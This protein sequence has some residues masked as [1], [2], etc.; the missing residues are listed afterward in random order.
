MYGYAGKL[1]QIDLK[2]EKAKTDYLKRDEVKKYIGGI[3]YALKL[4]CDNIKPNVDPLGPE[5][6][7]V[8]T[9][10]PMSGIMAPTGWAHAFAAKSPLTGLIGVSVAQGFF[11]RNMKMAG[12]DAIIFKGKSRNPTF[13]WIDDGLVRFMDARNLWGKSPA[14]TEENIRKDLGDNSIRVASIGLSGERLARVACV[15]N[16]R[17]RVAGRT[18]M[19][20]VMGSKNLKAIAVLGSKDLEVAHLDKLMNFCKEFYVKA[21]G[22]SA[23]KYYGDLG[24]SEVLA[25]RDR[26]WATIYGGTEKYRDLGTSENLLVYNALGCLPTRNFSAGTFEGAERVSGEYL[27]DNFIVKIHACSPCSISCEHIAIV[28]EGPYKGVAVRAEYGPIWAFGPNCGIDRLDAILKAIE[29]CNYYGLDAISTGNIIGFAMDCYERGILTYEDTG[30]EDLRFGN[31]VG[32]LEMIKKIGCREGFGDTLAEGVKRAAQK[33]GGRAPMLASHIKGLEMPGYDIRCSKIAALGSA[34]SFRGAA[35]DCHRAHFFDLKGKVNRFAVGKGMGELVSDIEDFHAVMDSLPVCKFLA[36]TYEGFENLARLHNFVTGFDMK[37][38]EIRMVG[39]R[40]NNLARLFNICQ[41]LSRMD[42]H[43]PHKVM[44][45]PVPKGPSKGSV[46][47]KKDLNFLIDEYYK[48]RGWTEEG[49][50]TEE[51]LKDLD[52]YYATNT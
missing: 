37:E 6:V 34:V 39:E 51:K 15:V 22:S 13:L 52:I 11:A 47:T 49:I 8:V 48:A 7:L 1:L 24:K 16:D 2:R 36:G 28:P 18:G 46:V 50:P 23:I 29:L 25:V 9:T 21:R 3:G 45:V 4:A 43:L 26:T 14:T 12:Y 33:I 30:C 17:T 32:M 31:Y 10:G 42:D 38:R 5:N 40:I 35:H 41:G 44:S 20:A 27:N 19:G